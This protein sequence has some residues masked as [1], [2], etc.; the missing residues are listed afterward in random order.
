[1]PDNAV[2]LEQKLS[3]FKEHWSPKIVSRF[4]ECDVMV[5]KAKGELT[6]ITMMTR[7]ISSWCLKGP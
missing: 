6:G 4:N 3:L 5:V 7:T 1:M 2:N